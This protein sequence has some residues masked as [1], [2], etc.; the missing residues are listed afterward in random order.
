MTLPLLILPSYDCSNILSVAA[1]D[2][3]GNL[4][5]FSNY[6]AQTVDVAA[7]GVDVLSTIPNGGYAFY[8]GTSMATPHVTGTAA[9]LYSLY[10]DMTPMEAIEILKNTG[11]PLSSLQ[12]NVA[13]GRLIN[14]ANAVHAK[15]ENHG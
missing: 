10:P 8:S 3:T 13:S 1:V 12:G 14:A 7:P 9:L 11:T 4:A 5:G 6:G 2:N 15:L